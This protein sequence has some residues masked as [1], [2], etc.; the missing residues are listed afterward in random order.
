MIVLNGLFPVFALLV[1]GGLLRRFR[2]T[3][4]AFL[5]TSDRLVYFIFFPAMLFW[6]IGGA[7]AED[8]IDWPFCLAA[9]TA[10]A[11]IYIVS[12]VYIRLAVPEFE[13]GSFSQ[14]CYRF[15][16]YIGMAIVLNALGEEGARHFGI[17]V[18][19][20]IPFINVLAVSTLIWY[21]G[22]R[23]AAGERVRMTGRALV[24]NPLILACIAGILYA[25]TV[26]TFPV[27]IDNALKLATSVTLPLALISIGGAL[28][29]ESLRGHLKLSLVA[30]GL[31]LLIF[32]LVGYMCLNYFGVS[33]IPF[34]V[35]MVFFA[36][37][38][39]TAIYVL[40]SQLNSSTDLASATIVL[41]TALSFISL[42]FV[43]LQ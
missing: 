35:G 10:V 6:K 4:E 42:S 37:P 15:N 18:G 16:T 34:Q 43:L 38:T 25:R 9:L 3:G 1:L 27:F 39:S 2:L 20:A 33:G 28:T 21:S 12:A 29:F 22:R 40:S 24:S 13:A 31:K 26:G 17:L 30:A 41:S 32:P 14:S 23:Y 36:L 8:G 5:K 19:F 11:I 7:R